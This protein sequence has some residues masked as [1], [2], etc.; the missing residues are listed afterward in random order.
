MSVRDPNA[1]TGRGAV[2]I[3]PI[4]PARGG[5]GGG[6]G[7]G[8]VH[9]R[10]IQPVGGGGVSAYRQLNQRKVHFQSIEKVDGCCP[11]LN[12]TYVILFLM[13]GAGRGVV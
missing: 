9:V 7:K 2:R 11:D 13:G 4:Q 12:D 1:K 5:G 3:R 10:P 6:G 8:A